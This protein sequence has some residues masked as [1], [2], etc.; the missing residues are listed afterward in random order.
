[1][2][3]AMPKLERAKADFAYL[4]WLG[5]RKDVP[6]DE[7]D[8]VR[9]DRSQELDRWADVIADLVDRGVSIWG[10]ANNHYMGHSPATLR[11][12]QARLQARGVE[13]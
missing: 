3:F 4:R 1:M 5:Q 12:I 6:D 8:R 9:I 2:I 13:T 11:E 10:F 7:Y